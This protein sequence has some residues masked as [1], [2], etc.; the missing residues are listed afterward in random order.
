MPFTVA[1]AGRPNVGKSTL[2]NRLIGRRMAIVSDESGVTRDWREGDGEL[3]DLKFRVLDTAGLEGSRSKGS[4]PERTAQRTRQALEQ[5]D[6]ILFVVD[7]QAGLT[8]DDKAVAKE[9]RKFNK[10]VVLL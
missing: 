3:F 5:T 1:I 9:V 10:P 2:F 8:S 4:L 6:V 7:A